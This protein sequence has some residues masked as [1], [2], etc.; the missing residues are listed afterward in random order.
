MVRSGDEKDLKRPGDQP[1]DGA[2]SGNI[3]VMVSRAS[4][5][6]NSVLLLCSF[7]RVHLLILRM[8]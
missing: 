6:D 8:V 4:S 7:L 2:H 1:S 5:I 3:Y